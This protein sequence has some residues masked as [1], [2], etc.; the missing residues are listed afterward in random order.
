VE[1]SGI[2][3]LFLLLAGPLAVA[4]AGSYMRELYRLFVR[5]YER[6]LDDAYSQCFLSRA[7][8]A[9]TLNANVGYALKRA[10]QALEET[11]Q[12]S[13]DV[14]RADLALGE[15]SEWLDTA[16]ETSNRALRSLERDSLP[17]KISKSTFFARE[18][19]RD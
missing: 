6:S 16:A 11:R 19:V 14:L 13:S 9:R 7:I 4:T 2:T 3:V 5:R 8:E 18:D 1:R 17:T 15:V 12:G 10:K